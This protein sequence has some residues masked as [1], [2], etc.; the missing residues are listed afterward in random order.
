MP[1]PL[2]FT[3]SYAIL[4]IQTRLIVGLTGASGL[5]FF[6]LMLDAGITG[7]TPGLFAAIAGAAMTACAPDARTISQIIH[8]TPTHAQP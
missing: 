4:R 7:I 6:C 1:H 3:R 5:L 8:H 2:H